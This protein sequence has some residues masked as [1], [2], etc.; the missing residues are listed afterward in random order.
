MDDHSEKLREYH[1]HYVL[2]QNRGRTDRK[3]CSGS[4]GTGISAKPEKHATCPDVERPKS[5]YV[6]FRAPIAGQN[7]PPHVKYI[8]IIK[9]RQEFPEEYRDYCLEEELG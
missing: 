4:T 3:I 8:A 7:T 6:D 9:E 1:L 2:K 5:G